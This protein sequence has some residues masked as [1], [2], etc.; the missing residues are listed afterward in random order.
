MKI[1]VL[2]RNPK[3]YS[4]RRLVEAAESR[5]HEVEVLDYL[6][7]NITVEEGEPLIYYKDKLLEKPDAIIPRIGA[8]R[9]FYGCAVVR[10][11]EMMHV[12]TSVKSQAIVRSR[13]KLRS[14]QILSRHGIPM[15]K[16]AFSAHPEQIKTLIKKV[17]GPPIIIKL[18]EGTQGKGVVLAETINAAKSALDAFFGLKANI[19]IQEYI[20]EAGGRDIR[21]FVVNGRVAG[22]M[23]RQGVQGEFRSNL[24][25]GGFAQKVKLSKEERTLALN[26]AKALGLGIAGVDLLQSSRGPLLMEVNSSPGLEGIETATGQDIAGTIIQYIER[27]A[28]RRTKDAIGA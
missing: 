9:T 1:A 13:D 15:P 4:T 10:Q 22:A 28:K 26:A 25:Q 16:T 17:G 7:C 12:F 3:L 23:M 21:V 24:H 27:N 18:L 14:M 6:F 19:L 8:S 20:K 11:F 5:G 2:S